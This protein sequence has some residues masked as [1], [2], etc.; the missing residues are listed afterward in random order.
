MI[1]RML[2]NTERD[3]VIINHLELVAQIGCT[4]EERVDFQRLVAIVEIE[5]ET[6]EMARTKDL[7]RGVCY[8]TAAEQL[9]ALSSSRPWVL[10]EELAEDCCRFILEQFPPAQ[11]VRLE[12]RKFPLA[13]MEWA[14]V[15]I[16]RE[17]TR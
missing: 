2:N 7:S 9:R 11:A 5:T 13:G 1:L 6:A 14:G 8:K 15:R 16:R 4:P 12:L 10:V 3:L 17:R